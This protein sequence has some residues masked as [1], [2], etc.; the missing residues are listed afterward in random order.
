MKNLLLGGLGGLVIGVLLTGFIMYSSAAGLMLIE[1]E[2]KYGFEE[3]AIVLEKSIADNGWATP[4]VHDLQKAMNK[5]GHDV[6]SVKVYEICHPSH[7]N[8][9]L[10]VDDER[11]VS[12][13]MPCRIAIY[14]KSDGK[15]YISRMNSALMSKAMSSLIEEVMTDAGNESE[16]IMNAIIKT[17][18]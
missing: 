2:S 17:E 6:M 16:K 12:T 1:D 15:T 10:Q 14:E 5:F 18:E 4:K 11:I 8:K 3:T 7:A 9:I 13:L